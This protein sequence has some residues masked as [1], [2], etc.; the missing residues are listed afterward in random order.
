MGSN[1]IGTTLT[2]ED[3]TPV[4]IRGAL[5][6]PSRDFN[7]YQMWAN[8]LPEIIERDLGYASR[9]GLNAIRTW[10][11][12]EF[13][14][15]NPTKHRKAIEHFLTAA[16]KR[17]INVLL[18][19]FENVGTKPTHENLTNTDPQ[20]ATPVRSPSLKV[21]Q[22]P[23]RWTKPHEF[24]QWF[25]NLHRNDERLLA[26][27]V[28]NEPG[29]R[30]DVKKFAKDMFQTLLHNRGTI[31]LTVGATSLINSVDYLDWGSDILQFHY[32]Y[33]SN[34]QIFR[35]L[36]QDYRELS[37]NIEQPIWL[38]EWQKI[39]SFGWGNTN[40]KVDDWYPNYASLAPLLRKY[41]V[42]NFFW[43]LMLQPAYTQPMRRKG[44]LNGI[45]H[46]DGA[47]WSLEDAKAIKAM[48]GSNAFSGRERKEW[49]TWARSIK[50][51]QS[52]I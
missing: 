5:Y 52:K 30:N 10:V 18:S 22:N 14:L 27:E 21:I 23:K 50:H 12:Y 37:S 24:V 46:E 36:L 51:P 25:M 33:P 7:F 13:W 8:Y 15:E 43:S 26:I 1:A 31:P 16:S 6:L 49:P 20:T 48:G 11:S 17:G 35:D 41:S 9:L 29:W 4:D 39:A 32:N 38:T 3:R 40:K 47:V 45:F 19:L 28:M 34:K 2:S 44:V 42:D